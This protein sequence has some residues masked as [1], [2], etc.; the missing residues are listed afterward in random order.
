M[1]KSA[2]QTIRSL[3]IPAVKAV[4]VKQSIP[5]AARIS[6]AAIVNL[7]STHTSGAAGTAMSKIKKGKV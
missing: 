6:A 7:L 2:A 1:A 3:R 4:K 5:A